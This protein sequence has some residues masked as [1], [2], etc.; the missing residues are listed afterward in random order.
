[1]GNNESS[2]GYHMQDMGSPKGLQWDYEADIVIIGAGGAGLPAGLKAIT[3]GASVIYVEANWDVGGHCAV[4]RGNLHS[5]GG[6]SS[7]KKHGIGDCPDW[8]YRDHTHG[9]SP[10]SRYNDRT[11]VRAV[12]DHMVEAYEYLLKNG[13]KISERE[14]RPAKHS[15]INGGNDPDSVT[16]ETFTDQLSED[17][18]SYNEGIPPSLTGNTQPGIGITRPL[19][20]SAREGGAQFLLNYHMD[21]IYRERPKSGRVLGVCASYAPTIL[22]GET[23]PL[24]SHWEG[25][26]IQS[27]K[28]EVNVKAIKGVIIATGGHSGDINMRT[29]FDPRLTVEYDGPAG[30]PFSR[31]DGSGEYAALEV[32]ASWGTL[33]NQC[34]SYGSQLS[35]PRYI[36][37]RYGYGEQWYET[38]PIFKLIRATGLRADEYP[39]IILVNMLGQRFWNEDDA[40]A[41][42]Y[43]VKS[44]DYYDRALGSVYIENDSGQ[45]GSRRFGGPIWAIFDSAEVERR[46]WNIREGTV[47]IEDGRFFCADTIKDLAKKIVNK[48]YEDIK[49]DPT[50]LAETVCRYNGYVVAGVDEEWGKE[51]LVYKIEKAPFY[52]A[53]ATP[54]CHDTLTGIRVNGKMQVIDLYG[55]IIPGLYCAGESSAGMRIHGLGRVI[56][57]GYIAGKYA[58]TEG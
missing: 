43:S 35:H 10:S 49:M 23:K 52:A 5:G 4:N 54:I 8:Y 18:V 15:Y 45:G 3:E 21:K 33:A 26:N 24:K 29:M 2:C 19:E 13:V 31:Q 56:T 37:C 53:W 39:G 1:M 40:V 30:E 14:P 34:Q 57:T 48:Y 7:Q 12:A 41:G 17:W 32:G 6:T 25:G 50:T 51:S 58:A 20:R 28:P 36:G 44:H 9:A 47:D 27:T 11:V 55:R 22:P 42:N 46:G 38:S 16:R